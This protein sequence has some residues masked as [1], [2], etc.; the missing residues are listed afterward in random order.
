MT[1][2]L[3]V[4]HY[5]NYG[6]IFVEDEGYSS[7]FD[8]DKSYLFSIDVDKLK[9]FDKGYEKSSYTPEGKLYITLTNKPADLS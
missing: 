4:S 3:D 6:M 9:I 2:I 8:K 7:D 5:D 1:R